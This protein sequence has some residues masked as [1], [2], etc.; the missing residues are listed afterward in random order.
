M[1]VSQYNM[2]KTDMGVVMHYFVKNMMKI[3]RKVETSEYLFKDDVCLIKSDFIYLI[4]CLERAIKI[5]GESDYED[6]VKLKGY[7]ETM[8][9]MIHAYNSWIDLIH[10]KLKNQK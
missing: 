2:I 5:A 9:G 3:T 6:A 4:E 8:E 1:T 7:I 10:D